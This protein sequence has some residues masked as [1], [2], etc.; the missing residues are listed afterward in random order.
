MQPHRADLRASAPIT[1]KI[2]LGSEIIGCRMRDDDKA[3]ACLE[4][5]SA[6]G[7]PEHFVLSV[8]AACDDRLARVTCR[9][10]GQD[11]ARLWVQF[12]GPAQLPG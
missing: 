12:L 9:K 8:G 4:L 5:M 1:A 10:Q 6:V 11:G 7:I 3:S 2:L